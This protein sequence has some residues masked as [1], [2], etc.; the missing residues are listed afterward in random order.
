M[1]GILIIV[2]VFAFAANS[3]MTRTFQVKM[4]KARH[5]INL[6]QSLLT[7][8]GGTAYIVLALADGIKFSSHMVLPALLFGAC[9]AFTSLASVKCMSIGYM[10]LTSV[11]VNLSL[12]LPVMF[13]WIVMQED[14]NAN[15]VIGLVLI[16][17]TLVLSSLSAGKGEGGNL[18]I[19]L[20]L[21]LIAFTCNG[22][23]AI[24]QK[25]Y[26]A[27]Y[28]EDDLILFMGISYIVASVIFACVYM[29]RD[30]RADIKF[31]EQLKFPKLLPLLGLVSGLGSFV[32]NLILGDLCDK[33]NGGVLYPCI[34]GGLCVLV[35]IISFVVFKEKLSKKKIAAICV[36]VTAI[37]LLNL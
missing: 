33:V 14:V 21:V 6:Y 7:F 31:S 12:I 28:G 17:I 2:A 37:I 15:S 19:W 4:Q 20:P 3:V 1:N 25:Q 27:S 22:S 23:T 13:S 5:V 29:I 18:K 36:G 35:S 24:L 32:G 26:K 8:F 30:H 10:S 9:F 34:N 11:I 16:I